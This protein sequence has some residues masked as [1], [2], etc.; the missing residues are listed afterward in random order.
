MSTWH[1]AWCEGGFPAHSRLFSQ[2]SAPNPSVPSGSVLWGAGSSSLHLPALPL[3]P[4]SHH[5][6]LLFL[7]EGTAP[8]GSLMGILS[9]SPFPSFSQGAF[10][11]GEPLS[12][13][14]T[15]LS[16]FLSAPPGFLGASGGGRRDEA[17]AG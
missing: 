8:R 2:S 17:G 11:P 13:V 3:H 6:K 9:S 7:S 15:T 14:F 1:S 4:V 16:S 5:W 12:L 10:L